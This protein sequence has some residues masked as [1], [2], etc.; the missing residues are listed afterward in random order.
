MT[1]EDY[2]YCIFFSGAFSALGAPELVP[3]RVVWASSGSVRLAAE[4]GEVP[5][6]LSGRLLADGGSSPAVG[7]WVAFDP[8]RALIRHVLP[9]RT[10]LSRKVAG[11]RTEEQVVAANV[12]TVF[13]VVG[14]DL[15]FNPRRVERFLVTVWESGASPVVILNKADSLCQSRRQALG[16]RGGLSWGEGAGRE[17]ARRHRARRGPREPG[18]GPHRGAHRLVGGRQV[19][20]HQPAPRRAVPGD[21]RGAPFRLPGTPHDDGPRA[22]SPAG[23]RA[24]RRWAGRTGDPALGGRGEPRAFLR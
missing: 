24:S 7:D 8:A 13:V 1:L 2:G 6:R 17:L 12:D 10:K 19:D 18:A 22:V 20:D 23:R 9:R 5:A 4:S 16:D 3:G 21:A 11:K 15:D 14:L